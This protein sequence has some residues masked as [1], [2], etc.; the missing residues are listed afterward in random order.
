M[1]AI[2]FAIL[3]LFPSRAEAALLLACDA[4]ELFT[5]LPLPAGDDVG[6]DAA[7]EPVSCSDTVPGDAE[8]DSKVPALCDPRGASAIAPP[9]IHAI[10]DARIEASTRCGMSFE[11]PHVGPS[12]DQGSSTIIPAGMPADAVIPDAVP[13]FRSVYALLPDFPPI[14]G[15]AR[16]GIERDVYHPPR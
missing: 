14:E 1:I 6:R 4:R 3:G 5:F 12:P 7:D 16:S 10:I 2:A 8:P 9:H 11:S 13:L 15:G